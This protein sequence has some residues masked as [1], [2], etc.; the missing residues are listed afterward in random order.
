MSKSYGKGTAGAV[1]GREKRK[2]SRQ[3]QRQQRARRSFTK[4]HGGARTA[5]GL[6]K[7]SR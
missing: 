7:L 2:A 1:R 4:R 5:T 3:Y 6:R